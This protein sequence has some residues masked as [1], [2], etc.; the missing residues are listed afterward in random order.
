MTNL[1]LGG[2]GRR[3]NWARWVTDDGRGGLTPGAKGTAC[4]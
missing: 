2:M 1:T 3:N 4:G